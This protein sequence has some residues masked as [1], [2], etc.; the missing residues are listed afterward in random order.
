M[1]VTYDITCMY[2]VW[3]MGVWIARINLL[4]LQHSLVKRLYQFEEFV[5]RLPADHK[6]V[7]TVVE[8]AV[9]ASLR[10]EGVRDGRSQRWEWKE[11]GGIDSA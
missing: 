10:E 2:K 7:K 4:Y 8:K 11:E 6:P 5:A 1:M 9:E 3:L